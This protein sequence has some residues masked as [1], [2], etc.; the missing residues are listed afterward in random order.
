MTTSRVTRDSEISLRRI[1]AL[2]VTEVSALSETLSK[3]HRNMV[4]DNALSIAEGF[5]SQNAWFRAVYADETPVGFVMLHYGADWDDGVECHGAYLWRLMIA[6]PF[7]GMGF[8][9]RTLDL[10]TS[11]VRSRG[12]RELFTSFAEGEGSPEKFYERLGFV[13]TGD[14][15]GDEPEVVLALKD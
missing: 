3:Q 13:R 1:S 9:R 10:V 12:Y 5:C 4:A 15:Y 6:T 7:Q 11:E 8:A 2:N 14:H